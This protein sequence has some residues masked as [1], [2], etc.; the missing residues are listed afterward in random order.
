MVYRLMEIP[1]ITYKHI[2]GMEKHMAEAFMRNMAPIEYQ[3]GYGIY[4]SKAIEKDGKFFIQF[5]TG[6]SCD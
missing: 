2:L 5:V 1:E 6:D 4:G 3:C